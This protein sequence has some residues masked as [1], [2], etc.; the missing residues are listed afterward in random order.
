VNPPTA[1][2]LLA[3]HERVRRATPGPW[4]SVGA[5]PGKRAVVGDSEMRR[6][7]ADFGDAGMSVEQITA[8]AEFGAH[9]R[10]DLPAA[11]AL[12]A[13]L[14][15]TLYHAR[16]ALTMTLLPPEDVSGRA[17]YEKAIEFAGRY[18]TPDWREAAKTLLLPPGASPDAV[19]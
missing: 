14:L 16:G 7:I 1:S 10:L 15:D 4:H 8:D 13:E 6:R 9:A 18:T 2:E 19:D 5:A 3:A 11:H 12:I 17:M